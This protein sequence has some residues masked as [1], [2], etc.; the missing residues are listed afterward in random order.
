MGKRLLTIAIGLP[1]LVVVVSY[2]PPLLF[3]SLAAAAAAAG[4]AEASELA[5]KHGLPTFRRLGAVGAALLAITPWLER[6]VRSPS[7]WSSLPV[8][9]VLLALTVLCRSLAGAEEPTRILPAAALTLLAMTWLGLFGSYLVRLH[10]LGPGLIYTLML[11]V[12]G[13]D[14]GAFVAGKLLGRHKMAPRLS[15]N[16]TMEGLAGGLAASVGG[17]FLGEALFGVELGGGWPV[18]VALGLVLGAVATAGDLFESAVKRGAGVKDSGALLP[19]HGGVLDRVDSLLFAA[20][21][22]YHA[23]TWLPTP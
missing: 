22:M 17:L 11:V 7:E 19:G 18:T 1:L 14:S 23:H 21:V 2:A 4:F 9:F 8:V 12:W 5:A 13:G 15:P 3:A 6:T 20:P 16:K 10:V